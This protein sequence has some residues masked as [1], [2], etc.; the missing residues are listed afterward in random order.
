MNYCVQIVTKKG[1]NMKAE[2]SKDVNP[3]E[4]DKATEV[5]KEI[6]ARMFVTTGHLLELGRLF[7]AVRDE[8]LYKLL[9]ASTFTEYC[10]YPEISYARTTVYSFIGIYE[11]YVL[12]LGYHPKFLCKIGHRSL[13]IV[14]PPV[15]KEDPT[16]WMH[17]AWTLS[18]GDLINEVRVWQGK[19]E[20][21]PIPK[22]K[23]DVYPFNFKEYIDFVRAHP[24]IV[25]GE[26]KSDAH[27][28]PRTKGVG[29]KDTHRIPLCR[30]CHSLSH[31][32]PFDFLWLYKDG[33]FDYFFDMFLKSFAIWK[34]L[35]AK[36]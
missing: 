5:H 1:I 27:H 3:T 19:P 31:Q 20:M 30:K 18:E 24:C 7:K 35:G 6:L 33:I 14:K 28:F 29:G 13:Q 34:I 12:K 11:L 10:G 23:E 9:G 26:E 2:I 8:K 32:D 21:L 15:Q 16:E 22:E 36:Q 25:C 4:V 17:K